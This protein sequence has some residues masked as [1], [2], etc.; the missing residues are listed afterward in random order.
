MS[1]GRLTYCTY[2]VGVRPHETVDSINVRRF[3]FDCNNFNEAQNILKS[4]VSLRFTNL[5]N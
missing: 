5:L 3:V 4:E 2:C 1:R